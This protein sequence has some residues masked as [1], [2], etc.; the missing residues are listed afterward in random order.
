MLFRS[1]C[2]KS[3]GILAVF[4][5]LSLHLSDYYTTRNSKV[6]TLPNCDMY[7]DRLL[8]L[9]FY[10]DLTEEQQDRVVSVIRDFY[11]K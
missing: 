3:N 11:E 8:R 2:L 6:P 10:Y 7:A 4:H 5:Y 1:E 9:P